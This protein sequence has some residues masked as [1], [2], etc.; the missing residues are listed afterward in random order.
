[1]NNFARE[2]FEGR[3]RRQPI[4]N[5]D[6]Q[7]YTSSYT[8][9]HVNRMITNN[10]HFLCRAFKVLDRKQRQIRSWLGRLHRVSTEDVFKI[11]IQL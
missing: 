8:H 2:I 6:I 1:M 4:Q 9:F 10:N 5:T 7:A 11:V 3:F